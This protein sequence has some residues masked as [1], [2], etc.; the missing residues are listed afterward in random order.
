VVLRTLAPVTG[1]LGGAIEA[2]GPALWAAP[3]LSGVAPADAAFLDAVPMGPGALAVWRAGEELLVAPVV[4]EATGVRRAAA[5]DGIFA[6]LAGRL[7]AAGRVRGDDER[8]VGVDQTNESVI[9]DDAVVVKLLRRTR[10]GAQPGQD[11]PAH[12]AAVGFAE[13]PA[14]AGTFT[15]R[16][17][18]L[19]TGAAY[20]ARAEDGWSWYVALVEEAVLGTR[21]WAHAEAATEALGALVARFQRALATPSAVLPAPVDTATTET[22]AGWHAAATATFEEALARTD[23][24]V[25]ERLQAYERRVRAVLD[26]FTRVRDTPITRIHGDLHV[27]QILRVPDGRMF[28]SDLDGDP[29]APVVGRTTPGSPAR[30]VASMACALDHAGRVVVRRHPETRDA[31][32]AWIP[33]A[34]AAFR[35]AHRTALGPDT[36]LVDERLVH[37]FAV[38]QE[39]HEFVYAARFQPRWTGVPDAA[40]PAVLAWADAA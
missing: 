29:V 23:G 18:L 14:P 37:P 26:G 3:H 4:M 25:H 39:A 34:R 2:A 35:A 19:A 31:V 28:V 22:I 36:S 20:L 16:D 9:V 33:R 10:A 24:A 6:A 38:A 40:L 13:T 1:D 7:G 27:G 11:L 8:T 12:L 15:W 32:E 21:P 5:G 17:A 30:D